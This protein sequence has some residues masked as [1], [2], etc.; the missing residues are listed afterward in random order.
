MVNELKIRHIP[1]KPNTR[2]FV[3]PDTF[4]PKTASRSW[5]IWRHDKDEVP[6]AGLKIVQPWNTKTLPGIQPTNIN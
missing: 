3:N 4:D 5:A 2:I 6:G 1:E